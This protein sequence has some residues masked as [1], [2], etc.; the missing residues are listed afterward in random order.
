M[1]CVVKVVCLYNKNYF[2]QI[3][4][5]K[6]VIWFNFLI[7]YKKRYYD[8]FYLDNINLIYRVIELKALFIV[9]CPSD[10]VTVTTAC[11]RLYLFSEQLNSIE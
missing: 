3:W 9:I 5:K 6:L 11:R 4:K 7:I 2:Y 1:I 8:Q 10:L